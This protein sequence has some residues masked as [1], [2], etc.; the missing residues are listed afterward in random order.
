MVRNTG[1]ALPI[2]GVMTVAAL[3]VLGVLY[4]GNHS[5]TPQK[6]SGVI[7]GRVLDGAGH[8]LG[9]AR[10]FLMSVEKL[11]HCVEST[12]SNTE[13]E[14]RLQK[15][16]GRYDLCVRRAGHVPGFVHNVSPGG[17]SVQL[18]GGRKVKLTINPAPKEAD[19]LIW[20]PSLE[21]HNRLLLLR[22]S[23]G[24][25][26][27]TFIKTPVF[28]TSC[29]NGLVRVS[30]IPR[31][32]DFRVSVSTTEY[33]SHRTEFISYRESTLLRSS[34]NRADVRVL[35]AVMV[36]IKLVDEET[37]EPINRY[38]TESVTTNIDGVSVR[39]GPGYSGQKEISGP[40]DGGYLIPVQG[41][42]VVIQIE[43]GGYH[44]RS[45]KLASPI[46]KRTVTIPLKKDQR[47]STLR[48]LLESELRS[49]GPMSLGV[50][51]QSETEGWWFR[52]AIPHMDTWT[53]FSV[54]TGRNQIDVLRGA[55]LLTRLTL[56]VRSPVHSARIGRSNSIVGGRLA[57]RVQDDR[58][59]FLDKVSV[60]V[61][62]GDTGVD[63]VFSSTGEDSE[64]QA[65]K[66][67]HYCDGTVPTINLLPPGEY[68][69]RVSRSGF[70]TA[71]RTIRIPESNDTV[72]TVDVVLRRGDAGGA[73]ER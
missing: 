6:K 43:V 42:P 39:L 44:A 20:H 30:G 16:T 1:L 38:R 52:N 14:F 61:R 68:S 47:F 13:G 46:E 34:E 49:L 3:G 70:G 26:S 37:N 40:P 63:T 7:E 55:T 58:G 4:F 73:L 48:L 19:V 22:L 56:S 25:L 10:V 9:D 35:P 50:V 41:A 12:V 18:H 66:V 54:P 72:V 69:V 32:S 45:W 53:V 62:S 21:G 71:T 11:L 51:G 28:R 15:P 36:D 23:D 29:V 27:R 24:P 5:I 2:A 33:V 64:L 31:A 65:G 67:G 60:D 59:R 8:P 57:L 17:L